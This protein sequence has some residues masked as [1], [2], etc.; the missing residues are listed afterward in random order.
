[1]QGSAF[2]ARSQPKLFDLSVTPN[3]Q[4]LSL[5]H[6]AHLEIPHLP[7]LVVLLPFEWRFNFPLFVTM[8]GTGGP[9]DELRPNPSPPNNEESTLKAE[10]LDFGR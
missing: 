7:Q 6:L 3:M 8:L 9:I 4:T 5:Y 10:I 2:A 1:M